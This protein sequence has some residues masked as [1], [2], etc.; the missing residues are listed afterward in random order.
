[1][2]DWACQQSIIDPGGPYEALHFPDGIYWLLMDFRAARCLHLCTLWRAHRAPIDI[3]ELHK[4][5]RLKPRD[6]KT[7]PKG[8]NVEKGLGVEA[9]A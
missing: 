7:K 3:T 9:R 5:P 4:E 6:H 2:Q 1:M 8:M